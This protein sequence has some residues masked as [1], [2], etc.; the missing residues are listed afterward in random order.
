M[1]KLDNILKVFNTTL[2]KLNKLVDSN[3]VKIAFNNDAIDIVVKLNEDMKV[4]NHKAKRVQ[5]KLQEL[6]GV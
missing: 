3:D 4:E 2:T 6:L 1:S 5:I